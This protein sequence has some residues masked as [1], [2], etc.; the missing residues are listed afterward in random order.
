MMIESSE[1]KEGGS[2]TST[3]SLVK[4]NV[5]RGIVVKEFKGVHIN[6]ISSILC[7]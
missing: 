5:K 2:G 7:G 3:N 1:S 4:I 6:V